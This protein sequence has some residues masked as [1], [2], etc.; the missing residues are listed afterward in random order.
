MLKSQKEAI[1]SIRAIVVTKKA[2]PGVRSELR[3]PAFYAYVGT[4]PVTGKKIQFTRARRAEVEE[5]IDKFYRAFKSGDPSFYADASGSPVLRPREALDYREAREALDASGFAGLTILEVARTFIRDNQ[6]VMRI[7]LR[8]AYDEYLS[9]F[10]D[11]QTSHVESIKSRVGR[12][13]L[14]LDAH[15][16]VSEITPREVSTMLRDEWGKAAP[17]TYNG[18]LTYLRSFFEWCKKPSRR[19]CRNN[20][21]DGIEKRP[22]P[23]EEPKFLSPEDTEKLFRIVEAE[24]DRWADHAEMVQWLALSYFAGLRSAEIHR[25]T[26]RDVNLS[27]GWVRVARPKGYQH[28]VAPRMVPLTD[29]AKAWLAAYPIP[30]KPDERIFHT[31]AKP[32]DHADHLKYGVRGRVAIPRNAGRHTFV[33]MHVAAFGDPRRTEILVGTSSAM[34]VNHYMGLATKAQGEAYFAIR[35]SKKVDCEST[36]TSN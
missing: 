15:R 7:S 2:I 24:K 27:E 30:R 3:Y 31:I 14:A 36:S 33:T 5:D 6:G 8:D 32:D 25:L 28:G 10:A 18:N 13:I 9:S 12:A 26:G 20:P 23:Y 1:D 21:T 29:A 19:Y 35:P 11:N 22:E 17:K 34:R 16:A 4:H